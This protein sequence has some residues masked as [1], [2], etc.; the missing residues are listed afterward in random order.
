[1]YKYSPWLS[2]AKFPPPVF[3]PQGG[4]Q[5]ST[6]IHTHTH[7]L[8]RGVT[9]DEI[10]IGNWIYWALTLVTTS[11]YDSLTELHTPN[12]TVTTAHN[13]SS[14]SL[15]AVAWYC[16]QRRTFCIVWVPELSPASS[17]SFSRLTTA[18][19]NWLNNNF[20]QSQ[21]QSYVIPTH[22]WPVCLGVKPH[23]GLMTRFLFLSVAGL[24]MWGALSDERMGLSFTIAAGSCQRSHSRVRVPRD[25]WPDFTVWGVRLPTPFVF[26][27]MIS[28]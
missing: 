23:L 28:P 11:N 6:G 15:V 1:M 14:Q 9:R 26:H 18:T 24:L 10:W 25:L 17:T 8:P 16:C 21:S 22:R 4:R 5:S 19:L 7:I 20:S 13:K 3:L 2:V 27:F 12:I